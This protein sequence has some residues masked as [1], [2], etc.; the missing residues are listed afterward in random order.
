M[1]NIRTLETKLELESP[2]TK[3][4]KKERKKIKMEERK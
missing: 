1:M 2:T 3:E 4:G